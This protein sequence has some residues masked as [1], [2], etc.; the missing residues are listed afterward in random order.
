MAII[1]TSFSITID[2]FSEIKEEE[3]QIK[4]MELNRNN[5]TDEINPTFLDGC[6][7]DNNTGCG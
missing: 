6:C 1:D 7:G 2:D 4:D 3:I 5:L